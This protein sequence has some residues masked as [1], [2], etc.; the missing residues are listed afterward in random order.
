MSVSPS[1][2]SGSGREALPDVCESLPYIREW[3]R[4]TPKC[5]GVVVKPAWLSG[6][7]REALLDVREWS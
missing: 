4:V 3:L 6:S 2:I 1:L 5:P 7:G